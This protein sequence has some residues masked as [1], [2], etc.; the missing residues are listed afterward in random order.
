MS[1]IRLLTIAVIMLLIINSAMLLFVV[2]KPNK[3]RERPLENGP[4]NIIIE[5]LQLDKNQV[6]EYEDLIKTHQAKVKYL[7][8]EVRK[9]KNQLFKCLVSNND[10]EAK[11]LQEKIG[12]LQIEM[13][14]NH[15]SHFAALKKICKPNQIENFNKLSLD[16]ARLLAPNR[17][18]PKKP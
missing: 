16:L 3:P 8:E 6:I 11:I 15:Y 5:R 7:N 13:E 12:A 2:F 4:K 17:N 9:T 10:I 1:K 14:E 18:K